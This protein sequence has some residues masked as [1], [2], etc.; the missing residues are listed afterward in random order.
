MW[1]TGTG[2]TRQASPTRQGLITSPLDSHSVVVAAL[3]A[4]AFI[5]GW[6]L[7]DSS[8]LSVRSSPLA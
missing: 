5:G 4:S 6:D 3:K 7:H 8:L 1:K 2:I